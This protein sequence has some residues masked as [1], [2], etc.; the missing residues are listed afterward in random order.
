MKFT[1]EKGGCAYMYAIK[2][3]IKEKCAKVTRS[4]RNRGL[5]M[6]QAHD[7]NNYNNGNNNDND[8][9]KDNEMTQLLVATHMFGNN[10]LSEVELYV[11]GFA[12]Y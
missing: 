8:N 11:E 10:V 1:R 7:N 9:D 12:K 3:Q 4:E 5:T 2:I 6:Q